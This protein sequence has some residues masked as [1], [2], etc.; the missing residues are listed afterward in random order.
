MFGCPTPLRMVVSLVFAL[1]DVRGSGKKP[2]KADFRAFRPGRVTL[3]LVL[4]LCRERWS[5]IAFSLEY[6]CV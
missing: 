5:V 2:N 3:L 4:Y 6:R 1:A